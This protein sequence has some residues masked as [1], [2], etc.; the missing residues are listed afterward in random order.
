MKPKIFEVDDLILPKL[1]LPNPCQI[2][3]KI[4][5]KNL[6][7]YIGPRDWQWD[8]K[9]ELLVGQGTDMGLAK[10]KLSDNDPEQ[11]APS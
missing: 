5:D 3:I 10:W 4:T 6:R 8:M 1:E 2:I 7:L 9:T 11:P